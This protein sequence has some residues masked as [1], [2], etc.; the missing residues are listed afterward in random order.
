MS[1]NDEFYALPL[2]HR[3]II[4]LMG[5]AV[6]GLCRVLAGVHRENGLEIGLAGWRP[7]GC[8]QH[9]HAG[10]GVYPGGGAQDGAGHQA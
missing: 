5:M 4:V 2:K 6:A 10:R 8:L 3:I 1:L 7:R 9:R